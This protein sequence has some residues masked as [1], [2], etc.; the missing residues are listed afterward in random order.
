M[1]LELLESEL[2]KEADFQFYE[3]S[4][5]REDL[6]DVNCQNV[7]TTIQNLL[8]SKN[9]CM[10]NWTL[11]NLCDNLDLTYEKILFDLLEIENV[12]T[13]LKSLEIL[14]NFYLNSI[15]PEKY[16][17]S[18]KKILNCDS[19]DFIE[20]VLIFLS[21]VLH[22]KLDSL[23]IVN[24]KIFDR[25][26]VKINFCRDSSFLSIIKKFLKLGEL[27]YKA[28]KIISILS[29]DY[30]CMQ[31]L[32][33][34]RITDEILFVFTKNSREKILRVCSIVFRN[35]IEHGF[36]F[37][38]LKSNQIIEICSGTFI[39]EEMIAD[40][41]FIKKSIESNL[42][43][44]KLIDIYFDELF[45]G[46]LEKA[47]YHYNDSFWEM[48]QQALIDNKTEIIKAI[49]KYLKASKISWV[50]IAANDLHMLMK[51]APEISDCV[52]KYG[53]KE[54]LFELTHSDNEDIR[55][56][57]IQTLSTCISSEWISR[58]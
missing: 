56:S 36:T 44:A 51:V 38:I 23:K 34:S 22:N 3:K 14:T 5:H 1:Y 16:F 33:E 20:Q 47:Q 41:K 37:T 53:I 35:F 2:K 52:K 19:Y 39:D 11:C 57:A 24:N 27:Q 29:F 45:G 10:I 54:D 43:N 30:T 8:Q 7:R 46:K 49:K 4:F 40:M 55:F 28:I 32:D 21:N 26:I 9:P 42:K 13:K 12:Y 31:I 50:C 15:P 6:Q 58:K 17:F 18:L 25:N 48:N